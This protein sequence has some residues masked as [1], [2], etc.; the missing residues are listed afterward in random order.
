MLFNV[1]VKDNWDCRSSSTIS[2]ELFIGEKRRELIRRRET[3]GW[4]I[5]VNLMK[6]KTFK[7]KALQISTICL[8]IVR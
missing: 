7:T 1:L 5:L 3:F 2:I 4:K 6:M 8:Q